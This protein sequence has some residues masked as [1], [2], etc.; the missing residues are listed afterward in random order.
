MSISSNSLF[1]FTSKFSVLTSI[2]NDK[3]YG[4]FCK[5][6]FKS[7]G[8]DNTVYVPKISFCDI[9][10]KKIASI[11]S[12]GKF[13]IGLSKEWAIK[14]KLNPVLYLEKNSML[15]DNYS[16]SLK[17]SFEFNELIQKILKQLGVI[18]NTNEKIPLT[19]IQ[20]VVDKLRTISLTT[21]FTESVLYYLKHYE[22]TLIR[23]RKIYKNYKFYDEREWCFVPSIA[24]I[25]KNVDFKDFNYEIW[26]GNGAKPILPFVNL[27]FKFEDI[28][29]LIV[30]TDSEVIKL[31]KFI[32]SMDSEK[33]KNQQKELLYS[34]LLVLK[35][36]KL[37][38]KINRSTDKYQ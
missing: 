8:S 11:P 19:E 16:N 25:Y 2:L 1:H 21:S 31:I 6:N 24:D 7:F 17:G 13:G 9:P 12:Y 28:Q 3:F 5:E 33:I 23:G 37:I 36:F 10:L 29:H 27:S 20:I 38:F 18:L 22:D 14:N 15:M 26:R 35:G 32:R 30:N 4:S 34:K